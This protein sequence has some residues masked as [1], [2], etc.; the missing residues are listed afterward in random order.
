[1]ATEDLRIPLPVGLDDLES[2]EIGGL[3]EDGCQDPGEE[4]IATAQEPFSDAD[5][6]NLF[7]VI[8]NACLAAELSVSVSLPWESPSTK[9]IFDDSNDEVQLPFPA[10]EPPRPLSPQ[11]YEKPDA[12][13]FK[14]SIQARAPFKRFKMNISERV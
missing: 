4:S 7:T 5:R 12:K 9:A 11:V 3:L 6:A 2:E 14:T 1:M 8:D 10:P 13:R